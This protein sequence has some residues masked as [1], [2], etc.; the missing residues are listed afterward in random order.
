MTPQKLYQL[1]FCYGT[2]WVTLPAVIGGA[3][4]VVLNIDSDAD[5]QA[6]Y[7]TIAVRQANLLIVNWSGD[8]QIA[9]SAKGRT[10]FNVDSPVAAF[11]G[12]G[13]LPYPFNPPRLFRKN[14]S[15]RITFTNSVAIATDVNLVLHG[16][17]L[18]DPAEV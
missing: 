10:L 2:G 6:N 14:A 12:N 4:N 1:Y 5:F 9:D 13:Q 18:V 16:N 7:L 15:V 11:A 3:A 17:K 8:V